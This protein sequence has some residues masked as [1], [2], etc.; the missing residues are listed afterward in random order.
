[1]VGMGVDGRSM[2]MDLQTAHNPQNLGELSRL[3]LM[4]PEKSH[5]NRN[6]AFR[7]Y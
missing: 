4:Q 6:A 7:A 3:R 1:M 5:S 2:T